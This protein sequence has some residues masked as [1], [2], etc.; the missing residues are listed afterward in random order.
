L[1]VCGSRPRNALATRTAILEAAN[2]RFAAES[3][4][5]VGIRDVA[6]DVG[7]DPAL[8][9]RY[10]GSKEELFGAVLDNCTNKSDLME[11]DRADFGRRM[12]H[13][14]VYGEKNEAKMQWLLIMLRSMGSAKAAEAIQKSSAAQFFAPFAEWLGGEHAMVR[15]RLCAGVIMGVAVSR[16]VTGGFGLSPRECEAMH[17]RLA[18]LLQGFVEG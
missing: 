12:A 18:V 17:D 5:E 2:R 10:F 3:Y 6:R 14:L 13:E 15:A 8:I 1:P 9:S 4:E 16:D 7:V 11:G